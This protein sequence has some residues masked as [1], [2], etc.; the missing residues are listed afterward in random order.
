[1]AAALLDCLSLSFVARGDVPKQAG[2]CE[3]SR[4]AKVAT[5]VM[6]CRKGRNFMKGQCA[7]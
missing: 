5:H 6:Y 3:K 4:M 7:G 2:K 1:M